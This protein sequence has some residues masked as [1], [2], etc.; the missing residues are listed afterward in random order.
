MAFIEPSEANPC[1]STTFP[2]GDVSE[3]GTSDSGNTSFET[4]LN[5]FLSRR[6]MLKGGVGTAATLFL[7]GGLVGCEDYVKD[8]DGA[9]PPP[10]PTTLQLNFNSVAHSAAAM[11][12]WFPPATPP[13]VVHALGDPL[14]R[15]R[16][17]LD[18][19]DRLRDWRLLCLP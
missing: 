1:L 5:G 3:S 10:T 6:H 16:T 14:T 15:G 13:E 9:T 12:W 4:V 7:A 18:A 19:G 11:R 17:R 2:T 8:D